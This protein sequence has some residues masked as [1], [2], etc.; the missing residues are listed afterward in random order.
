M[1]ACL[2]F[3][4]VL[5]AASPTA[6]IGS[7]DE[8]D[9]E[10]DVGE[11]AKAQ[12]EKR[13]AT[14]PKVM[15]SWN[16]DDMVPGKKG[17]PRGWWSGIWGDRKV[18][19]GST[20]GADG[21]GRAFLMD[22]RS[23][24][25]GELQ[26]FS[27]G[28]NLKKGYWYKIT[29]KARGFDHPSGVTV[30]V[31]EIAGSWRTPCG[32]TWVRLTDEWKEYSFGGRSSCSMDR[33]QFG[34]MIGQGSAGIF[35]IDDVKVE[36][37]LENPFPS[38]KPPPP[39]PVVEG[40]LI[41]RG[42]FESGTDPFWCY[43]PSNF[44]PDEVLCEPSLSRADEGHTGTHSMRFAGRKKP[45]GKF[46][47]HG[48]IE[49]LEIPVAQGR[50]YTFALWAKSEDPGASVTIGGKSS[51]K[52]FEIRSTTVPLVPGSGWQLVS[53]T[54]KP[55]PKGVRT[56]RL[57]ITPHCGAKGVLVDSAFFGT[58]ESRRRDFEPAKPFE[59]DITFRRGTPGVDPHIVE[60][61]EN[62]PL[63]VGA[64]PVD[65]T[66]KGRT[67]GATLKVTGF[68]D[69][70]GAELHLDLVA[71]EEKA[72]DFDPGL[73]GILRVELVP[74]DAND[75]QKLETIMGRLPK[76]RATGAK[77]RFGIHARISPQI[78][79]HARAIGLTWERIHDCS[80]ITKMGYANPKRGEYR[81]ADAEVDALRSYGFSILGMPDYPPK[82][83]YT[84]KWIEDENAKKRAEAKENAIKLPDSGEM[85]LDSDEDEILADIDKRRRDVDKKAR[86][87]KVVLCDIEAFRTYCREL[88]AHFKGRIDHFEMW[89][90][91]YWDT[92]FKGEK[93]QFMDVFH[94]GAKG[95]REGNPDAKVLGY[96]NEF[97]NAGQYAAAARKR[98]IEEKVD[99]NSMHYYYMGVPGTGEFGVEKIVASYK[100]EF[101][102][103]AGSELWNTEGNIFGGSSFYSWRYD[104]DGCESHTAFGVRGWCDSFFDGID[105]VFIFGMFN[106]DGSRNGGLLNTID[107]D[108]S[109]TGWGAAT[110]T[111]AY[112][113][114]AM[115]P[116]REVKAPKGAKL[117]V[118]SDG[119][120]ASAVIFDDCLEMGRPV[121]D[122]AKLPAG[123]I[124]VDAM[125]ND[126]RKEPGGK[127]ALSPVPFFVSAEGVEPAALG[128]AIAAAV[129]P[130]AADVGKVE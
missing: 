72:I 102:E 16:F 24:A 39:Q 34:I 77:G 67:V 20:V 108:R 17:H 11:K 101:K 54:T 112:F 115:T 63:T 15:G 124:A 121:F 106:T 130:P 93:W 48:N 104:R 36:E 100:K 96:C 4:A 78:L 44:D 99:Y 62:L 110:A 13:K 65:G 38:P 75:A 97:N 95:I 18:N 64:W 98:P 60:W 28:W 128:E 88:A 111:T 19:Y 25:G 56:V 92:F 89:N 125:G 114:D 61:G 81:W 127:R 68:P 120:R 21:K 71:G 73:N 30:T 43:D 59:L 103:H 52:S 3:A 6:D 79:A 1:T 126:L 129:L 26:V 7:L 8:L 122:A 31:R 35:A 49:S 109:L 55:M 118:F 47:C 53:L 9:I 80:Q 74:D 116:H 50:K 66:G 12:Y 40:N 5:A 117:R 70:K 123:W 41:P 10:L 27:P 14:P 94:A 58:S 45:D 76:P 29:F 107:Y 69:K 113:I 82:W 90:E 2:A 83:F 37:Y 105:R 91:P 86:S 51:Q 85:N 57:S 46:S 22:V 33:G 32:G 84:E 119:V 42:S 23:I 87:Y